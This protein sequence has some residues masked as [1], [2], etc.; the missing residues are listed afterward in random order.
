MKKIIA[1][2]LIVALVCVSGMA[3]AE[4][5]MELFDRAKA[6]LSYISY[7]EYAYA[8][9]EMGL[10]SNKNA[11]QK[12]KALV[13]K[14]LSTALYGEVQVEIAV[15]YQTDKGYKLCVPVE[16][17]GVGG[18]EALVMLSKDGESFSGY[19]A[20]AWTDCVAEAALSVE[21]I[22]CEQIYALEPVIIAD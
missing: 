8:L 12:L 4:I 2:V 18:V 20:E 5:D 15:C 14:S 19:R 11:V 9:E 22:W 10:S 7:G 6:A 13:K 17:P 16:N 21:S 3:L 1:A